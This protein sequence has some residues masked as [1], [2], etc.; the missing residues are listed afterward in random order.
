[1]MACKE[2]QF[3]GDLYVIIEMRRGMY[4]YKINT[5]ITNLLLEQNF[6][7]LFQK[8]SY[9]CGSLSGQNFWWIKMKA[10]AF[11]LAVET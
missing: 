8:S 7:Q 2:W 3:S 11:I 1:M 9:I 10:F 6:Y 5:G 4:A